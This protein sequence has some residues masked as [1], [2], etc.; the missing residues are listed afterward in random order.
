MCAQSAGAEESVVIKKRPVS[1]GSSSGS[2][3]QSQVG[4]SSSRLLRVITQQLCPEGAKAASEAG[5]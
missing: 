1:L 2:V 4:S 5:S 3:P